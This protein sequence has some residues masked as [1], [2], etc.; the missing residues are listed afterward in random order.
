MPSYHLNLSV[1]HNELNVIYWSWPKVLVI[2]GSGNGFFQIFGTS[3]SL[4]QCWFI[5]NW[6]LGNIFPWK[7]IEY[8]NIFIQENTIEIFVAKPLTTLFRPQYVKSVLCIACTYKYRHK[9]YFLYIYIN[10]FVLYLFVF[11]GTYH[12]N[13]TFSI[14]IVNLPALADL[15]EILD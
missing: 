11:S 12:S 1:G 3:H 6:T 15:N 9:I 10:V 7:F 14:S 13:I 5:V 8:P 4:N 2:V